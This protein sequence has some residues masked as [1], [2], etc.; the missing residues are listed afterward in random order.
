MIRRFR[1]AWPA[2]TQRSSG[3]PLEV[4][5]AGLSIPL[6]QAGIWL[7]LLPVE[8]PDIIPKDICDPA[9]LAIWESVREDTMTSIERGFA[10]YEAVKYVVDNNISGAIVETGVWRGGSSALIARTLRMLGASRDLVLFDTFSGM[11]EAGPN[12]R[13]LAGNHA[14][15]LIDGAKGSKV[16]DL[17]KAACDLDTVRATLAATGYDPRRIRYVEGDV[18]ETLSKTHTSVISLLRLD[19]DFYDST[20][21]SLTTLYQ[22]VS[23]SG[24]VIVDDYGHWQGARKACDDFFGDPDFTGKAPLMWRIDYTGRG[25]V[26]PDPPYAVDME[27]YDYVPPGMVDPKLLEHFPDAGPLNPWTVKWKY[28]R[29]TAPHIFRVDGRNEKPFPIGYASYEEAVCLHNLALL[30]KGKRGLEIG[31]H[32]GWTSA[33]LRAAGLEMDFV[34]IAFA[35]EGR[36]QQV[37]STLN[38]IENPLPF[39]LWGDPSPKCIPQVRGAG[40]DPFS[41]AFVDGNHDGDAPKVDALAVLE[42]CAEDAVV[43]FH[44]LTSPDVAAGLKEMAKAGWNVTI[45]KTMQVLGVAWRGNVEIPD[46]IADPNVPA[47]IYRH[48]KFVDDSGTAS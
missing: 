20:M 40:D 7:Y 33:H 26:K 39:R 16:A 13:D 29:P 42:Q 10:L 35:D 31:S 9:F 23:Q 15:A 48:L 34:D 47:A 28:L 14:D 11:T 27:R 21:A 25:F 19:T 37:E 8:K 12:D 5:L 30:F 2:S 22:R 43:V 18:R 1:A 41:F 24:V 4:F 44:D 36:R 38:Q 17:V 6:E 3:K 46:H 32:F 45:F